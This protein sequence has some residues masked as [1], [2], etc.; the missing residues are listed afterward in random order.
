MDKMT[1]SLGSEVM[2]KFRENLGDINFGNL[3][4]EVMRSSFCVWVMPCVVLLLSKVQ[5]Y[6]TL[7]RVTQCP[8]SG[9]FELE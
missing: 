4:L 5:Q 1:E 9:E 8:G 2:S 3:P 7:P 6:N